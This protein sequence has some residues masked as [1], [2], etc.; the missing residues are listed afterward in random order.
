MSSARKLDPDASE[1][2][3]DKVGQYAV[4]R[5]RGTRSQLLSDSVALETAVALSYN[6]VSHAV[7][8]ASPA[9]L[10][11]FAL[12]FSL[13][14]GIIQ[15]PDELYDSEVI[16]REQGIEVACEI[17]SERMSKLK[18]RRRNLTGRTGCGICGAETLEQAVPKL[19]RLQSSTT[20]TSKAVAE[21]LAELEREQP[22]QE[23]TGSTH[24]AA[25]A[26]QKGKLGLLRE[27]VGRHNALDK[28]IGALHREKYERGQGF[29]VV[30]SRA[31]FEMV[32]KT[33]TAGIPILVA[34]SAPTSLAIDLARDAGL[35][36]LG[37]AR[38]QDFVIYANGERI[39]D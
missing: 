4:D 10:E 38:G 24:A 19:S 6:G 5:R 13:S 28:L 3:A 20:I 29:A 2:S 15:T 27:D 34:V 1:G 14:E 39:L 21:A 35:A 16:A 32:Q 11:E 9:D 36:L 12:G 7:M 18:E 37:F 31:S 22:T 30:T 8:M 25:W 26:D 17:S 23:L 33:V